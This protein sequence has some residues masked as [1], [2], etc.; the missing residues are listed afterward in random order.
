[1]NVHFYPSEFV[2]QSR[3]MREISSIL[4]F[5]LTSKV[6]AF[7]V[8]HGS[9]PVHEVICSDF[10]IIRVKITKISYSIGKFGKLYELIKYIIK[11]IYFCFKYKPNIV[12]CHS[13]NVLFIGYLYKIFYSNIRLIY[14]PHELETERVGLRGAV[15]LISRFFERLM[16]KKVD[17]VIVVCDPIR[18]WYQGKYKVD[19]IS[20]VRNVSTATASARS[21][22]LRENLGIPYDVKLFIYQ[23]LLTRERG[24]YD[25]IEAFSLMDHT[26]HIVFMGFGPAQEDVIARAAKVENVHFHPAV[27]PEQIGL[28]TSGADV[29][30]NFICGDLCKSYELSLPNKFFEYVTSGCAVLA[31]ENL[32]YLS[33][34]I[35]T[36]GIGWSASA[37]VDSLIRALSKLS[38]A[39]IREKREAAQRFART[40]HWEGDEE[41]YRLAFGFEKDTTNV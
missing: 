4:K 30:V 6:V 19:A 10:E 25:L 31:S 38:P 17:H 35:A 36:N 18:D 7:G 39:D 3:I 37:D 20:V 15:Q 22:I 34:I 32:T 24:I 33:G 9:L 11:G 26:N 8:T 29:G 14:D 23:G 41:N 5:Q 16:I 40:Q 27:S 28:Y 21:M 2:S 12:N 1:M 13:L